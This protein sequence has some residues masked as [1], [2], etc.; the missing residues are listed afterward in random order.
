MRG[1]D[2]LDDEL[3]TLLDGLAD[4]EVIDVLINPVSTPSDLE[5][6]LSALRA[7]GVRH[8]V[9]RLHGT[10]AVRAP[11]RL[12]HDLAGRDDV[13]RITAMPTATIDTIAGR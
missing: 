11:K 12:I 2:K 7:E 8:N 13:A 6:H 5:R 3:L 1:V 9:L 10:L 4:D